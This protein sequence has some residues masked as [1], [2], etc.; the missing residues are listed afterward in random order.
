MRLTR[1]NEP[2][3]IDAAHRS[4]AAAACRVNVT[5]QKGPIVAESVDAS[6]RRNDPRPQDFQSQIEELRTAL[7]N[8]RRTREYSQPTEERLAQITVQCARTVET[9][10]QMEQRRSA[11]VAVGD[12]GGGDRR[13]GEDR[14]HED[15]AER[16][17]TLERAI[18]QEWETLQQ[19]HDE[20]GKELRDQKSLAETSVASTNLTLRGFES[21]E[22]RLA[23]LEQEMQGRMAQLSRD[24]QLVVAELRSARP[25]FAASSSAFPLE[26]VMRIHEE[27]RESGPTTAGPQALKSG[28]V[29]ALPPVAELTTALAARLES[30]ERA[31]G[32]AALERPAPTRRPAY[33]VG[34]VIVAL[35]SL[36]VF[37]LWMQR[38]FDARLNAAAAQVAEAERERDATTA[39]T[40]E[41]AARQ[42]ADARQ[43]A[44]EAQIVGNV[45]A[46]P[47]RVRYW[48]RGTGDN[49]RA[50]AQVL[51]SRSRGLVFSASRLRPADDGKTYQL[52]LLTRGGPVSAGVLTPDESGRVT[53]A[54]DAAFSLPG[55]LSGA[56]VTLESGGERSRP[57]ADRVLILVED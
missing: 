57:S 36:A 44:S 30:L 46:A 54:S 39:A 35:A 37:G 16:L 20:P 24:L 2:T 31:V 5:H 15:I 50:Y 33:L 25:S 19:D 10:Q 9:W 22:A 56:L 21:L 11:V 3:P 41:E 40:R 48:L 38:R 51:F 43:A 4:F 7:Q 29:H 42:V 49:S 27:L 53:L 45:L 23:G 34:G 6:I 52:W 1:A 12:N 14:R 18:E 8:W 32:T 47:D 26:S 13:A 17:R 28:A 55:R